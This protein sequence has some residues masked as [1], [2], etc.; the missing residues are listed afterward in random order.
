MNCEHCASI[1]IAGRTGAE[2]RCEGRLAADLECAALRRHEQ[3][4]RRSVRGDFVAD[5]VPTPSRPTC[6]RR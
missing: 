6:M 4:R 2:V 1:A 5:F 3:Q